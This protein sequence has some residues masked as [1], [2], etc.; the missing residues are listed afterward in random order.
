MILLAILLAINAAMHAFVVLRFGIRQNEPFLLYVFVDAAL[1]I[2]V[3]FAVPYALWA[4]LVLI[5]I[6][7]VG[8][9]VTFGR[10]QRDKTADK[11]I[12]ALDAA[13]IVWTVYLLVSG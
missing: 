4:T 8:L 10:P 3:F 6:G 13:T 1:A 7:I 5:I 12:W 2:A 9:T 11:I